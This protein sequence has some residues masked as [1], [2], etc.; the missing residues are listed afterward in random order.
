MLESYWRGRATSTRSFDEKHE[1]GR[2]KLH[3][4]LTRVS[5]SARRAQKN[6]ALFS[7]CK[8]GRQPFRG[9]LGWA[10]AIMPIVSGLC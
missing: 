2:V 1:S 7:K 4:L 10:I 5:K 9:L 6:D 8:S 3:S